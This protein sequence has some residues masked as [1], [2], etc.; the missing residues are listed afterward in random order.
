MTL[1]ELSRIKKM[2]GDLRWIQ[3]AAMSVNDLANTKAARAY[4][5]DISRLEKVL[6]DEIQKE[7]VK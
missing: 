3:A 2:L 6:H 7:L 1:D 5:Q 4:I